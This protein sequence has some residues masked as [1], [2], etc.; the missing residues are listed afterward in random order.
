VSERLK[1]ALSRKA[2]LAAASAILLALPLASGAEEKEER[3]V[4]LGFDV[5]ELVFAL[6]A[7]DRVVGVDSSS[8]YPE[9]ATRLP[10]VGYYRKVAAEGILSLRPTLVVA[11]ALSGPPAALEQLRTAG[12]RVV[13]VDEVSDLESAR[14]RIGTVAA[15]IGRTEAGKALLARLD[16]EVAEAKALGQKVKPASPRVLFLFSPTPSVLN[17]GGKETVASEVIAMAGGKLAVDSFQGYRPIS[18]EALVASKPDVLLVTER[19][20]A[21]LGGAEKIWSVP[22]LALTPAG[23]ARKM[24][25]L[26]DALLLGMGPRIGEAVSQ[27]ARELLEAKKAE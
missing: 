8:L 3:L 27:L 23:K 12:V 6:G 7:G 10:K 13:T 25:V 5:T 22:G 16:R 2:A 4:T 24:V 17:V 26:D 1:K 21:S 15:A 14:K 18:T 20:L 9:E 19:T 11:S